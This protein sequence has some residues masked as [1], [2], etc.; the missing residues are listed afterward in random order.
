MKTLGV[1]GFGNF[2][3]F[4]LPY[5]KPY[6]DITVYRKNGFDKEISSLGYKVGKIDEICTKDFIMLSVPVQYLENILIEIKNK[7]KEGCVVFDVSSVKVIPAQLMIKHLPENV[8]IIATHPLFGPQSG[9][10]GIEGLNMVICDIRTTQYDFFKNIFDKELKLNVLERTPEVHDKQMAYVQ[11]LT[12]FIG[13]AMNEMDIPDV[14][15][16]TAAYDY[17]LGIKRNL[18]GDSWDLF[19][20]IENENPF[21]KEVRDEFMDTLKDLDK[22]LEKDVLIKESK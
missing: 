11:A 1:I 9:K 6:F 20:T 3:R 22:R 19:E 14:E 16:K 7:V 2:S 21:A 17:L 4:F 10:N 8:E 12:H 15:Q 13:R 5:L 18:G